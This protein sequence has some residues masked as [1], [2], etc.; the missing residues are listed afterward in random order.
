MA[1]SRASDARVAYPLFQAEDG[2]STPTLALHARQLRFER[3]AASHAVP[4]V[5]LWHSRLPNTQRGPWQFAYRASY[6]DVT[7]AVALWH[8]PSARTLPAHWVELRRMACAPDAP[9]NTA[10]RFLAWMVRDLRKFHPERKHCI[11]YQDTSVHSGGIYRA[12]GWMAEYTA[13][14]RIRDR[15]KA[16]AGTTRL[17]RTNLNGVE[18]DAAQKIRWGMDL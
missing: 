10:S 8:N 17:Y 14:P 3:C 11:S 15:S 2:G 12:A 4:L 1:D 5:R 7:Y 18:A 16:R 9:R 13:Q 6:G